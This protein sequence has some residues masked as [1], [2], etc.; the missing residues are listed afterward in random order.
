MQIDSYVLHSNL[1][2]WL[3]SLTVRSVR[4]VLKNSFNITLNLPETYKQAKERYAKLSK[5]VVDEVMASENYL[6]KSIIPI[7]IFPPEPLKTIE[8]VGSPTNPDFNNNMINE[9]I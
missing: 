5:I 3:I 7:E 9:N 8:D 2:E 1:A 6:G 4:R